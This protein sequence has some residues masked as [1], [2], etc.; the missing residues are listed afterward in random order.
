MSRILRLLTV[1]LL[2]VSIMIAS[3]AGAV[4]AGEEGKEYGD[5]DRLRNPD[6]ERVYDGLG[7]SWLR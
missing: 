5:P 7:P 2:L 4:F 1:S 3:F 6:C